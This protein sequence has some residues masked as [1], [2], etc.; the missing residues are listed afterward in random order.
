MKIDRLLAMTVLLLNRGRVS[1]KELAERFEVST[2]TIYRDMDTLGQSGIPIIAHQGTAGGFEIM[3]QY[4]MSRQYLTLHE[5][6]AVVAA[7]KGINTVMDDGVFASL[8]EKVKAQ[9]NKVDQTTMEQQGTGIVFDFNPWGQ[10]ST[11][12][13]KVN[14]LRG[15]VEN[16][17]LV[18]IEYLN[19]NGTESKRVVEP[20]VL[21]LKANVWYLHAYCTL[22]EDFRVFRLSRIQ[23]LHVMEQSF[24][25]REVPSLDSYV[26]D[27]MWA[28][29]TKH[30]IVLTFH[31]SVRYRIGDSFHP[32]WVTVLRD[33]SIQV[34]GTF[35]LDEWFYG[36]L[37]SYGDH[38]KVE[39][40]A[41]VA[42]EVVSRAKKIINRY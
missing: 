32:D 39:K 1:A 29:H 21:I 20:V 9:L 15:A 17:S 26:W 7:V 13:D 40:P 30:E 5:I 24:V 19:M 8:L 3:E 42:D 27:P 16:A 10:G 34:S 14:R 28:Q 33:G 37:L 23:N 31:S 18:T 38:V 22:R 25:R 4:T 11:A 12:R 35:I 36:M 2:K 6:E 41:Y